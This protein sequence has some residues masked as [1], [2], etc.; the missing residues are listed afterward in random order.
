MIVRQYAPARLLLGIPLCLA[1]VFILD[2]VG[3]LGPV[4][5]VLYLPLIV[6][7]TR[8]VSN[9]GVAYIGLTCVTMA[10]ASFVLSGVEGFEL[11]TIYQF[12]VISSAIIL[13]TLAS[14]LVMA[15]ARKGTG[16]PE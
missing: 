11:L 1:A 10:F 6:L 9:A 5:G 8:A 4:V 12:G 15:P 13:T 2:T 14:M 7:S 16:I 3:P